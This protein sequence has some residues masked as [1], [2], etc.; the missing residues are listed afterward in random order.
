MALLGADPLSCFLR[1]TGS[2]PFSWEEQHDCLMLLADWAS[3]R[4]GRDPAA[5]LRGAYASEA[6]ARR[7]LIHHGGAVALVDSLLRPFGVKQTQTP[8]R[9]DLALMESPEGALGCIV[10]SGSVACLERPGL[11]FFRRSDVRLAV[12]W[13][14]S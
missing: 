7:V 3:I 12:A 2:R 4:L 5:A 10:L 6:G 1:A 11:L 9:G 8:V 13:S 14:L